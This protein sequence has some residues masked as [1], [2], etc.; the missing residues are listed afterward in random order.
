MS[1]LGFIVGKGMDVDSLNLF[2]IRLKR[3]KKC[4][5]AWMRTKNMKVCNNVEGRNDAKI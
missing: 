2:S 3:R 1:G 5:D 4:I